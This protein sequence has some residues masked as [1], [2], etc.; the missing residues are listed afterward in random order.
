ML[1]TVVPGEMESVFGDDFHSVSFVCQ[2]VSAGFDPS[3][4]PL[5][6]DLPCQGV[7]VG[8]VSHAQ[9]LAQPLLFLLRP[10]A[11]RWAAAFG[12]DLK[13]A[14]HNFNDKK[15]WLILIYLITSR[16]KIPQG[17]RALL[18]VPGSDRDH[19]DGLSF[20]SCF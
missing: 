17:D 9:R 18:H 19:P 1:L 16:A 12:A 14:K 6:Q 10:P 15:Q 4:A 8:E 13:K 11:A 5:A 20:K 3:V 2:V 7:S